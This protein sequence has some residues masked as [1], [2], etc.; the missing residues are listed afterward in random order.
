MKLKLCD[1][2]EKGNIREICVKNVL[3]VERY[4]PVCYYKLM[5]QPC[6][7]VVSLPNGK[8]GRWCRWM[9]MKF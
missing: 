8:E 9:Y 1:W 4:L 7:K 6:C 3:N 5:E 2:S